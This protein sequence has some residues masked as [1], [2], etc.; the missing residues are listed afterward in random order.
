MHSDRGILLH[1]EPGTG[2]TLVARALAGACAAHSPVPVT[3]FARKAADCLGKFSGEAERT[4]RLL[5]HE[6]RR[7]RT[8][9][10]RERGGERKRERERDWLWAVQGCMYKHA[11][12]YMH[13][14]AC[15]IMDSYLSSMG[16][17]F[18]SRTTAVNPTPQQ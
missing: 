12:H 16:H 18:K 1:G 9:C 2:K 15:T 3:F 4:L 10:K 14:H 13:C 17:T 11:V 7:A 6:V 8:L 5:F